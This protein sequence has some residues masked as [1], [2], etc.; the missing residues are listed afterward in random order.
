MSARSLC[1]V[2]RY[3]V[4]CC[5]RILHGVHVHVYTCTYKS[6]AILRQYIES[7]TKSCLVTQL[8]G[9]SASAHPTGTCRHIY[10]YMYKYMYMSCIQVQVCI[11]MYMYI[12]LYVYY[13]HGM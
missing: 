9:F 8:P 10:M 13:V 11:H 5:L 7:Q 6:K 1:N 2:M 3:V 12:V 4:V